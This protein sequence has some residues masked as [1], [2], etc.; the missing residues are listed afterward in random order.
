MNNKSSFSVS[1]VIFLLTLISSSGFGQK[2]SASE[3]SYQKAR[4][5]LVSGLQALGESE[6]LSNLKNFTIVEK[7]IYTYVS[8]PHPEPEYDNT[9]VEETTVIDFTGPR[10]FNERN[11]LKEK[12]RLATA[13]NGKEG[14]NLNLRWKQATPLSSTDLRNYAALS[15]KLPHLL[16]REALNDHASSLRYLGEAEERGRKQ[17]VITYIDESAT[18]IALYFD[19]RT[20]LLTLFEYLFTS[21]VLGD[22]LRRHT[23]TGYRKI[24]A[25][26]APTGMT[27]ESG[28]NIDLVSRYERVEFNSPLDDSV[29]TAPADFERLPSFAYQPPAPYSTTKISDRVFL[30]H[31]VSTDSNVLIVLFKDY[32]MVVESPARDEFDSSNEKA[33]ARIKEIFPGKPIK[34]HSF[35]HFHGDHCGGT[36]AYIAEG[37]IIVTT[38]GAREVIERMAAAPFTITPD[39]QARNR[40]N[41]QFEIIENKKRVIRDESQAVEIYDVGPYP[42]VKEELIFYLP[43]EKLLYVG[44]FFVSGKRDEVGAAE[45][46]TLLLAE[47]IKQLGLEVRQIVD[48]HG[49]LRPI[50]D[51][52]KAIEKRSQSARKYETNRNF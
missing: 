49:R 36:R 31:G 13:I 30:M 50:E 28:G 11:F 8:R 4:K 43:N 7:D 26:Q 17:R 20:D 25:F 51:M 24:G 18:Q 3:T 16:L 6:S 19:A 45:D 22:T 34:Y 14:F 44:D 15:L 2:P 42:H 32:L 10:L 46:P 38:P 35:T 39:A 48:V 41:P 23:I 29:F 33:I 1:A 9:D 21:N 37:A 40:R 12:I 5:I 27:I 52:Y 47:K